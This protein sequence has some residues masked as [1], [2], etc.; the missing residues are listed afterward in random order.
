[1]GFFDL[2]K[3]NYLIGPTAYGFGQHTALIITDISRRRA[4]QPRHGVF[5][6]IFRHIDATDRGF[7]IEQK[8]GQRLGQFGLADTGRPQKQEAA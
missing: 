7:V 1:M 4:D 3:Q 6:H 8:F 2:V 5:F